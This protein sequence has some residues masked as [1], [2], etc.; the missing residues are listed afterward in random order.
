MH[1]EKTRRLVRHG[2]LVAE[3]EVTL[4]ITD[5]D[6]SPWLTPDDAE[7]LDRVREALQKGDTCAAGKL[8]RVFRLTPVAG[9]EADAA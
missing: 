3:V 6:W 7:K 5:S 9:V 8:A 2:D 1:T 4:E